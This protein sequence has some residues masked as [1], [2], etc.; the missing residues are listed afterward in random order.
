MPILQNRGFTVIDIMIAIAIVAI[1]GAAVMPI[2]NGYLAYG[3][4]DATTRDIVASA[5]FAQVRSE[6][7]VDNATWGIYV[8][9]GYITIF[10]GDS[11]ATRMEAYDQVVTYPSS[12]V[13]TGAQEYVFAKRTGRTM[14]GT[15][16]LTSPSMLVQNIV[17]NSVGMIDF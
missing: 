5:R 9:G 2:V 4:M 15:L 16:I 12:T 14:A 13:V 11:Y 7:G 10:R 1:M 8:G 3:K 6:A 17:V